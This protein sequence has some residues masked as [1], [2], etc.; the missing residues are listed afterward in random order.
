MNKDTLVVQLRSGLDNA[1]GDEFGGVIL[2]MN[3][4]ADR[5]EELERELERQIGFKNDYRAAFEGA[6]DQKDE[7][8]AS[9]DKLANAASELSDIY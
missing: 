1:D 5:I 6:C 9:A 4:A 3:Q 8:L 7:I 2:T